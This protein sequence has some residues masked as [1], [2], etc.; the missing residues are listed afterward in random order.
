ML[1]FFRPEKGATKVSPRRHAKQRFAV[2][3]FP[4][5]PWECPTLLPGPW[6]DPLLGKNHTRNS[7]SCRP[8]ERYHGHSAKTLYS[9]HLLCLLFCVFACVFRLVFWPFFLLFER[10]LVFCKL[11]LDL[12]SFWPLSVSFC[13]FLFACF[14]LLMSFCSLF[15]FR[16]F[17]LFLVYCYAQDRSSML[18]SFLL[19]RLI[20]L[21]YYVFLLF[22]DLSFFCFLRFFFRAS[23]ASSFI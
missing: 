11:S 7:T 20:L 4:E 19:R 15:S 13:C 5:A 23:S 17:F 2:K 14:L 9:T 8:L 6:S 16:S 21:S 10:F 1:S 3:K 22:L 12:S 18:L